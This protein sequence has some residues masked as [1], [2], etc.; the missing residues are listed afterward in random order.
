MINAIV[1]SHN[2]TT[3]IPKS[4]RVVS[5]GKSPIFEFLLRW[6]VF[7]FAL[8]SCFLVST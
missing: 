6:L 7:A 4:P 8:H 5:S 2:V 1:S 3:E